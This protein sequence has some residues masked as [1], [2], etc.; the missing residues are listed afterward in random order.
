MFQLVYADRKGRMY[1]HSGIIAVGRTGNVY[2]EMDEVET[3]PLPDGASLVLIPDGIPIGIRPNGDFSIIDRDPFGKPAFCVGALLPQGFTRT[4]MP[5]F[6]RNAEI[7]LPLF[8]YAAVAWKEGLIHVAALQTDDDHK[9]NPI[10][11][12]TSELSSL[13][14]NAVE[15]HKDNR[16]IKQL[17]RCA[18]KYNCFTA[19]NI[20]YKRWEGGIPVSPSC[21]ARCLGCIS[22]QP[23]ECCPSPQERIDFSPAVDEIAGIAVPHLIEAEDGIISF[24]QGCE[25][26]PSLAAETVSAAIKMIRSQTKS[27]TINMNTN[28]GYTDGI[29]SIC[30]AGIDSLRVST[31]S[32]REKTYATY[33]RPNNYSWKDVCSSVK[34]AR[35][36]GIFVSL[37]LLTLPGLTDHQ[38]E[39]GALIDFIRK[40]DVNMIQIRNLNI[41]PDYLSSRLKLPNQ[42]FLGI[43]HLVNVLREEFPGI[44]IGNYSKPVLK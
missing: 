41:D 20:F 43:N 35:Q 1:E 28:A 44:V 40:Y 10:N 42:R 13:V 29:K 31:I 26:E 38:D 25:G 37:N 24:G 17:S 32:A 8:G 15:L 27:G 34:Y 5:A 16:I 3:I 30:L 6:Q 39:V 7:P 33:Y 4:L 18:L 11:Y 19:Q 22:L 21:N 36:C 2:T 14:E 12:S 9:W 23:A